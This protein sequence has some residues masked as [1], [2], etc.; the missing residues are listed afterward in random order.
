MYTIIK[1]YY[2]VINLL[3]NPLHEHKKFKGITT[4]SDILYNPECPE[5]CTADMVYKGDKSEL[6]PLFINIHGGG[7]VS[8]DKHLRRHFSQEMAERGYMV[9]NLNYRLAGPVKYPIPLH[10][11]QD[12]INFLPKLKEEYNFDPNRIILSGDSAGAFFATQ[13]YAAYFDEAYRERLGLKPFEVDFATLVSFCGPYDPLR[14]LKKPSPFGVNKK[15]FHMYTGVKLKHKCKNMNEFEYANEHT[16]LDYVRP[17]WKEF[18]LTYAEQDYFCKGSGE[19]MCKKLNELGVKY[20]EFHST[21]LLDQHCYHLI[22]FSKIAKRCLD[23]IDAF[24]E[25]VTGQPI[26][27]S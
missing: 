4:D 23:K 25:R 7:F 3:F 17:D 11:C 27:Q 18:F 14:I 21:K 20:E 8:G 15:T 6:R 12:A 19:A 26:K 10:D 1:I 16:L 24:I 5:K 13:L 2:K 22:L 9:Y